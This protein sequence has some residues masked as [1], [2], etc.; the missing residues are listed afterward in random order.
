VRKRR[1]EAILLTHTHLDH[2][3]GADEVR[4]ATGAPLYA[5]AGEETGLVDPGVNLSIAFDRPLRLRPAE[6]TAADGALIRVAGIELLAIATP[7]HSPGHLS[8][9]GPGFVLTGD[10]LFRGSIGRTDL[11]G[12]SHAT[13][14]R[15]IHERLLTLAAETVVH[16]GHGPTT[17]IGD[18]RRENPFLSDRAQ[19]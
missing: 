19:P 9:R 17:T 13:L 12:G 7:G 15:S 11:P 14:L 10:A 16:P 3:F 6:R 18:E 1:V 5:P 8:W 2:I 4:D